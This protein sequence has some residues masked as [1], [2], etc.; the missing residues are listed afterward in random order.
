MTGIF[1]ITPLITNFH[2]SIQIHSVNQPN[3]FGES[4]V[5]A[6]ALTEIPS[7]QRFS[8]ATDKRIWFYQSQ[9]CQRYIGIYQNQSSQKYF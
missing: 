6:S 7:Y 9:S 2:T 8:P 5:T 1:F 3:D 4:R